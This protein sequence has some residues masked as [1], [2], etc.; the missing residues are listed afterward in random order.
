[1]SASYGCKNGLINKAFYPLDTIP[2]FKNEIK[3]V[4]FSVSKVGL[5]NI[6]LGVF[7]LSLLEFHIFAFS[8]MQH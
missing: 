2:A 6:E 1:M 7:F 5:V 8:K 3:F 4:P